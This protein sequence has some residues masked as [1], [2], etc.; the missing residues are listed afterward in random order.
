M[1]K[2]KYYKR[3]RSFQN[4]IGNNLININPELDF[5]N[6]NKSQKKFRNK[7]MVTKTKQT[8]KQKLT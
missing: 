2:T 1:R 6:L 5:I 3:K 7:T 8:N 4:E